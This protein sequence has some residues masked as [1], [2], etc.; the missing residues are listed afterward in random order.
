MELLNVGPSAKSPRYTL[1]DHGPGRMVGL[2]QP[3]SL[4]IFKVLRKRAPH[5]LCECIFLFC[6]I[7]GDVCDPIVEFEFNHGKS[8]NVSA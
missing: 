5:L 8:I 3:G 7:N 1:Q 2:C 4:K 6:T